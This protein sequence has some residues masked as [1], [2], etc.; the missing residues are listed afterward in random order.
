[1][2]AIFVPVLV[3]FLL[4]SISIMCMNIDRYIYIYT[5]YNFFV[6]ACVNEC[7]YTCTRVFICIFLSLV[8]M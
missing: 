3:C 5:V 7:V 6:C 4:F 2:F 8:I 1:M